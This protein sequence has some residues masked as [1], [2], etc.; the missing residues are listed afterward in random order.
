[1][2]P[3]QINR[4]VRA[5]GGRLP[6]WFY[7]QSNDLYENTIRTYIDRASSLGPF[8]QDA[9]DQKRQENVAPVRALI[10]SERERRNNSSSSNYAGGYPRTAKQQQMM[11]QGQVTV[12]PFQR[13]ISTSRRRSA[14]V[15]MGGI[16]NYDIR[17]QP[18]M[19]ASSSSCSSGNQTDDSMN[20]NPTELTMSSL[21]ARSLSMPPRATRNKTVPRRGQSEPNNHI[22]LD[23]IIPPG[24]RHHMNAVQKS[25]NAAN[26]H[27][28]QNREDSDEDTDVDQLMVV[29]QALR[30]RLAVRFDRP[31]EE[32]QMPRF[33]LEGIKEAPRRQGPALRLRNLRRVKAENSLLVDPK[34]F[35]SFGERMR[36]FNYI[37][38][39]DGPVNT[40]VFERRRDT[41]SIQQ[42]QHQLSQRMSQPNLVQSEPELQERLEELTARTRQRSISLASSHV[43]DPT[44]QQLL[45]N[46]S[47]LTATRQQ[48]RNR[49]GSKQRHDD[50]QRTDY[51]NRDWSPDAP[52]RVGRQ[53]RR[54][55][56]QQRRET[57]QHQLGLR[58][59]LPIEHRPYQEPQQQQLQLQQHM[60]QQQLLHLDRPRNFAE[61]ANG[62]RRPSMHSQSHVP[63]M[64]PQ[65]EGHGKVHKHIAVSN[66]PS[67]SALKKKQA[68]Q[69]MLKDMD[70]YKADTTNN[71]SRSSRQSYMQRSAGPSSSR[72]SIRPPQ[73]K[74]K[75][76]HKSSELTATSSSNLAPNQL[77]LS[78]ASKVSAFKLARKTQQK[79]EN[80]ELLHQQAQQLQQQA[81]ELP[82]RRYQA[83]S[84][85]SAAHPIRAEQSSTTPSLQVS[86]HRNANATAR[87]FESTSPAPTARS[88]SLTSRT[89]SASG[90]SSYSLKLKM[91]NK[92]K[93]GADKPTS[94]PSSKQPKIKLMVPPIQPPVPQTL[95][96]SQEQ[97]KQLKKQ[98][99][100]NQQQQQLNKCSLPNKS[101]TA[102]SQRKTLTADTEHLEQPGKKK[103]LSPQQQHQQQQERLMHE[104]LQQEESELAE[105]A[106]MQPHQRKLWDLTKSKQTAE[107]QQKQQQLLQ[108][109]L[110]LQAQQRERQGQE[111]QGQERQELE[112][113]ELERQE[114]SQQRGRRQETQSSARLVYTRE[115][116]SQMHATL[117]P[118]DEADA[119]QEQRQHN[120]YVHRRA[121]HPGF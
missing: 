87:K 14:S 60:Q 41:R 81:S 93:A 36:Q 44:V 15:S 112:R 64:K 106:Q 17:G 91:N 65:Y 111:H 107:E 25:S 35:D 6:N 61:V 18:I 59:Q 77:L 94:K 97:Q 83:E 108:P 49:G 2:K 1:M 68:K 21:G 66:T 89:T 72:L 117:P 92:A 80:A 75:K 78:S 52:E 121:W 30:A 101:Q 34:P 96:G 119:N 104:H 55:G 8:I 27:N 115:S 98:Q 69:Q 39:A 88:S 20:R 58:R 67:R 13:M 29:D 53:Q 113:Q 19:S 50:R 9:R 37:Q 116:A 118:R 90:S 54:E 62:E 4:I 47:A 100:E 99:Q 76:Q 11:L 86:S 110:Q 120:Q 31:V 84:N 12:A 7:R 102:R 57:Q 48:R 46:E 23:G 22:P 109:Q 85:A 114:R 56:R 95:Q 82:L 45:A 71:L 16:T 103:Q 24:R 43:R 51:A 10:Q 28:S 38:F 26:R 74:P 73:A 63:P 70:P 42:P 5:N 79:Q 40:Q 32:A 105:L 33:R 3:E